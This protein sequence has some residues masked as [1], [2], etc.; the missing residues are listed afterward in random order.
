MPGCPGVSRRIDRSRRMNGKMIPSVVQENLARAMAPTRRRVVRRVARIAPVSRLS[1]RITSFRQSMCLQALSNVDLRKPLCSMHD[2]V[3]R[4]C[5]GD[6][7]KALPGRRQELGR[8]GPCRTLFPAKWPALKYALP[9]NE[10]T[11]KGHG[12][13]QYS[14]EARRWSRQSETMNK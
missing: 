5:L 4:S 7:H 8:H 10:F 1:G 2:T 14:R 12:F 13:S 9:W 11:T 6:T 3:L